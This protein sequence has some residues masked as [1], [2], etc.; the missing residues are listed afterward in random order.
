MNYAEILGAFGGFLYVI[1]EIKQNRYMWIVG[2]ISALVYMTIF[3]NSS[4]FA[5]VGLQ[6]YYVIASIYGWFKWNSVDSDGNV[7]T[8]SVNP[9]AGKKV[10]FSVAAA[11]VG[12]L[13]LWHILSNYTD[14]PMPFTDALIASLSML[15]TYWVTNKFIQHWFLWIAADIL[16]V[17]MYLSQDLYATVILYFIYIFAAVAGWLHWRKFP[18]VLN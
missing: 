7:P 4:L 14:N 2:G 8:P 1:L 13:I 12:F 6:G 11:T 3:Y 18:R 9:L 16:A 5:S 17:W 15:A 10:F